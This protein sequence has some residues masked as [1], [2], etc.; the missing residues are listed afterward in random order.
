MSRGIS[1]SACG[2]TPRWL[3]IDTLLA[4]TFRERL[5]QCGFRNEAERNQ[6]FAD[7]LVRLHLL[8]Q[9]NAQL[10]F[11]KDAFRRSG[12]G[13]GAALRGSDTHGVQRGSG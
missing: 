13:R 11:G 6:Q 8:K 7:R 5:A 9:R 1:L 10:I 4:Q 12:S 3:Q 2:S